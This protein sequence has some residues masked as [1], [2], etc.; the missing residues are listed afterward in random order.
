MQPSATPTTAST[1]IAALAEVMQRLPDLAQ[2]DMSA[3]L[4]GVGMTLL[5]KVGGAS[6]PLYGTLFLRMAQGAS[7]KE[8]LTVDEFVAAA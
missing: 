4:K 3:L 6:G 1:W 8:E 5:S 7:G 2:Q